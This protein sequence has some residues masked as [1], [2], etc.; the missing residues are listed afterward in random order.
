MFQLFMLFREEV[1]T[2]VSMLFGDQSIFVT[3]AG[4]KE[5]ALSSRKKFVSSEGDLITYL[6][7]YRAFNQAKNKVCFYIP[8]FLD[9]I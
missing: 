2:I 3:P 9:S 1:I 7:I 5:E 8:P 6:N 4:K